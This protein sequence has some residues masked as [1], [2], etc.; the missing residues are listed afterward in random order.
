MKIYR[1]VTVLV[2]VLLVIAAGLIRL[3][4]PQERLE[5]VTRYTVSGIVGQPLEG[6]DFTL[7]VTRVKLARTVDPRPEDDDAEAKEDDKPLKTNGIFVTVEYDIVGEHRAGSA[8]GATL[9]TNEDSEYV[10]IKKIIRS[11]V[12]IPPPGYVESSSLVFEANPEDLSGLR[13]VVKELRPVTVTTEDY[14]V[15]L[16]V[17]DQVVA[18]DMVQNAEETYPLTDPTTRAAG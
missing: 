10:P 14:S 12:T 18:D 17:P 3:A 7:T 16:G 8:G 9:R 2:G 11:Q 1:P 4:L 13:M 6:K 5:D 15:D